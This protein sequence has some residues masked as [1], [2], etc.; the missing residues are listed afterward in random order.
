MKVL[1]VPLILST[2]LIVSGWANPAS[3]QFV[4]VDVN[5]FTRP[6]GSLHSAGVATCY[7]FLIREDPYCQLIGVHE[8]RES[9][10]PVTLAHRDIFS[11]GEYNG[12]LSRTPLPGRCYRAKIE[13]HKLGYPETLRYLITHE[14][15]AEDTPDPDTEWGCPILLDLDS[16][17]FHLG[18][19]DASVQF[20]L[21]ADG[22]EEEMAWTARGGGDA[23]LCWDRNGN[24]RIDDGRELFGQATLMLDSVSRGESGY[25]PLGQLDRFDLGGNSDGFI[26]TGDTIYDQLCVWN[27]LDGDGVSQPSELRGL[28]E[29]GV[30]RIGYEYEDGFRRD[31]HGNLFKYRAKAFLLNPVGRERASQSYD[32]FFARE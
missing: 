4:D 7:D 10:T 23:F 6:N 1:G 3:S 2:L 21:D 28:E 26:G 29:A 17:G 8:I 9:Y 11:F 32:V 19:L 15:C 20:D 25:I 14:E 31:A 18:G 27:D 5:L 13:A 24:G 30:S 22:V 16:N 12:F